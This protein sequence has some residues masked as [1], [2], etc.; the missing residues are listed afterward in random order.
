MIVY[1]QAG[2]N[3]ITFCLNSKTGGYDNEKQN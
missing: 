2:G 1:S 3:L